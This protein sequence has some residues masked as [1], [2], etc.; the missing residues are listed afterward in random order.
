MFI[1]CF[2]TL[3]STK[4]SFEMV[5]IGDI[6]YDTNWHLFPNSMKIYVLLLIQNTEKPKYWTG[7]QFIYS[8]LETLKKVII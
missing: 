2:T 6:V 5:R 3:F 8:N 4:I 1:A 7:Y